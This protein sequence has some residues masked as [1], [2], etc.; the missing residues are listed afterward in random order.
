M[1]M[2]EEIGELLTGGNRL[3]E[4]AGA[5]G[6]EPDSVKTAA[7][8]AVPILLGGLQKRSNSPGGAQA[9]FDMVSSD[10]GGVL[11]NISGLMSGGDSSGLGSTLVGSI[12]G[13]RRSDIEAT[14]AASSGLSLGSIAK[15]LPM[16]APL[17]TGFLSRK[18]TAEG[19]DRDGLASAVAGERQVLED[20]GFGQW[21]GL[22]D[23]GDPVGA[24][25]GFQSGLSKI[26][27]L[28]GLGLLGAGAAKAI[29]RPTISLPTTP[30]ATPGVTGPAGRAGSVE[31]MKIKAP[32]AAA[33]PAAAP[34]AKPQP[35]RIEQPQVAPQAHPAPK[36]D[37]AIGEP[38]KRGNGWL[39]W[40]LP[41]LL[42]GLLAFL[43]FSCLRGDSDADEATTPVATAVADDTGEVATDVPVEPTE[44]PATR[45]PEPEATE[46]PVEEPT[47]APAPVVEGYIPG[48]TLAV[49]E[50]NGV[51]STLLSA[52][53]DAELTAALE[54]DGP[55]T[56]LAPVDSAFELL[57]AELRDRIINDPELLRQVLSYHVIDGQVMT[58]ELDTGA[59]TAIDGSALFFDTDGFQPRVNGATVLDGD[60]TTDNGVIQVIDRVLIPPTLIQATGLTVNQ[61]LSLQP[62]LFEVGSARLTSE[63]RSVLDS[64]VPYFA[65]TDNAFE[66]SGH[67]DSDGADE[68]NL[69]L[70][71]DRA[72]SVR[73]YLISQGIDEGR[74]TA[75]GYGEANP[76]QSNDTAEGKAAN[77]RIEFNAA[78]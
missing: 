64:A 47:R 68:T 12:L 43:L 58:G 23:G 5:L 33:A 27:G 6:G 70:S 59:L 14:L 62:I 50:S 29:T 36:Y 28:G 69:A 48:R 52:V 25:K 55:L 42:V 63:G 77:R 1:A 74:L 22:L 75:V 20:V 44:L 67:T 34:V 49:A 61:A 56:L 35:E 15:F 78:S 19:L 54:V 7:T 9:L 57:P 76:V 32:T 41:L 60:I 16:A 40:L 65:S 51:F 38:E 21:L 53:N 31:P 45:V 72:D 10:E 3:S 30:P 37:Y 11:D 2:F 66:V 13:D 24:D 73:N 18:R 4:L 26:A 39:K 17:V 71:Q 8:A 46:V